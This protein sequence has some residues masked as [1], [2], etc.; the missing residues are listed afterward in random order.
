[1]TLPKFIRKYSIDRIVCYLQLPPDKEGKIL[2]GFEERSDLPKDKELIVCREISD[3]PETSLSTK[4]DFVSYFK[5]IIG[6]EPFDFL[7]DHQKF[8]KISIDKN[9]AILMANLLTNNESFVWEQNK[10]K[11]HYFL[12]DEKIN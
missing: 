7:K 12:A 9:F 5:A 11:F 6:G 3:N 10:K 8:N 2:F 1:M 4:D